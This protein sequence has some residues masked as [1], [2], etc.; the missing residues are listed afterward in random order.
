M[1]VST[2]KFSEM[3]KGAERVF[4]RST[5]GNYERNLRIRSDQG[6]LIVAAA[7][8]TLAI[9][10][11]TD[12]DSEDFDV[13]VD[14]D[15]LSA[16]VS[17]M[18]GD[19]LDINK[20]DGGIMLHSD[21]YH[22]FVPEKNTSW[23]QVSYGDRVILDMDA[24]VFLKKASEI[25]HA[26]SFKDDMRNNFSVLYGNATVGEDFPLSMIA[27]DGFRV[28]RSGE[29]ESSIGSFSLRGDAFE[30]VLPLL[31]G[32]EVHMQVS[33]QSITFTSDD[34]EAWIPLTGAIPFHVEGLLNKSYE[35]ELTVDK[36]E[37]LRAI[38]AASV[39][40]DYLYFEF[41][42]TT[43]RITHKDSKGLYIDITL[44]SAKITGTLPS[45]ICLNCRYL[46]EA[47]EVTGNNGKE[48]VT[49]SFKG[50]R[51][52]ILLKRNGYVELICPKIFQGM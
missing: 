16:L 37:L 41:F 21:N 5:G 49:I 45:K 23:M 44:E 30:R 28:A 7:L 40:D 47:V 14:A 48:E 6:I 8:P 2:R 18:N 25:L 1:Y 26:L 33:D 38:K 31:E 17:V 36:S 46:K 51:N 43:A 24:A 19:T 50:N 32:N 42:N 34:V 39:V 29:V 52:P 3:L 22:F 15:K 4:S 10:M 20:E 11:K 35:G 27:T 12:V 13:I 9:S